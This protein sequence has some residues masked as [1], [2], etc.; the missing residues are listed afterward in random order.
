LFSF[1][2][3]KARNRH[4]TPRV[5]KVIAT[6]AARSSG[7]TKILNPK[8]QKNSPGKRKAV[9]EPPIAVEDLS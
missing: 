4:A 1:L 5:I 8:R 6:S 7:M 2:V 3:L 9:H